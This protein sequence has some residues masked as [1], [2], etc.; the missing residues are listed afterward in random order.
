MIN[1]IQLMIP[2]L[3][4]A[5]VFVAAGNSCGEP[6][7]QSQ[8]A[9]QGASRRSIRNKTTL[10]GERYH[11]LN[12]M[13]TPGV[14]P[15]LQHLFMSLLHLAI[16]RLASQ[17]ALQFPA[18]VDMVPAG[19]TASGACRTSENKQLTN[20]LFKGVAHIENIYI[21]VMKFHAS[22]RVWSVTFLEGI[23]DAISTKQI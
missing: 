18:G 7:G 5:N 20:F 15:C 10:L 9:S 21:I 22:L 3:F 14:V 19:K 17:H 8:V 16:V 23:N 4:K 11:L 12:R 1:Q 13:T 6:S 2:L